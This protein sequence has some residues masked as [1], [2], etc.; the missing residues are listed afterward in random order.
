MGAMAGIGA[1]LGIMGGTLGGIGDIISAHK[2]KRPAYPATTPEEQRLRSTA[3]DQILAGGQSYLG[4][5]NLLNQM[6][7]MMMG[8]IPGMHVTPQA[9]AAGGGMAPGVSGMQDY[10]TALQNYQNQLGTQQQVTALTAQLKTLKKGAQK[11]Q[12]RQQLKSA[13][14]ALKGMPSMTQSERNV[15]QGAATPAPMSV[16]M[17][18]DTSGP[19]QSDQTAAG[20]GTGA[21]NPLSPSGQSSLASILGW[22]HG[23]SAS[24]LASSTGAPPPTG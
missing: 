1:G 23:G 19:A 12:V 13:K 9:A 11:Q 16:R 21:G 3:T 14:Q 22:L 4:G 18:T 20:G 2:Y 5:M 8:M 7:P 15:Y 10:K 17:G 6:T 24:P